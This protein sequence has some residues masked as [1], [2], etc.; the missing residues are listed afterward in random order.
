MPRQATGRIETRPWADGKTVTFRA[1]VR[2]Y[3][4]QWRVSLGTNHE[5]WNEAR[6]RVELDLILDKI[7]RGTWEPPGKR[8]E[9]RDDLDPHETVR[10]SAY[11]WWQRRKTE[12]VQKTRLDYQWRLNHLLRH[13]GDEETAGLDVRKVDDFRHKLVGRGLSARSVNMVLDLLAQVLDDAVEYK[14]LDAN[15]ARGKRRR[16][17]VAKSR[18]SFLEP[19]MV[20]DLLDEAGAWERSLP[21]HQHYGRRA[22]LATLCLAGPRISEL[23]NT[24]RARLDLHGGRLRVGEAKTAAGLRDLELTAFLLGELRAHLAALPTAVRDSHGAAL[25]VFPT[26]NGGRLNASNLRNRLLNGTPARKGKQPTKGVVQRVNERR[27]TEGRMLLPER[28]TPH[29]LRRTF[30]SLALAAG[31]DPRW[32]MGQLGHTD[33]R[34][35]LNLYAQ[36]MQRQRVDEALIWRLMRFP[37]EAE[38]KG[39][40]PAIETTNETT[41]GGRAGIGDEL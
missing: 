4:R 1:R 7:K 36:V 2:A 30:A 26:R 41:A 25:P 28:V 13:L 35:T 29:T 15:V 27:E 32:V 16:M 14:V 18:R 33:A 38:T 23:I 12:L 21:E 20:V 8:R 9:E 40:A 34:L 39:P 3:G 6:A 10:V 24:P 31:R 37:D 17:K 11:R 19:D 22:V 5:G